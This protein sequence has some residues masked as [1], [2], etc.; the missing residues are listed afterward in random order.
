MG[1]AVL[2]KR[3]G[4]WTWGRAPAWAFSS[5]IAPQLHSDLFESAI[6]EAVKRADGREGAALACQKLRGRGREAWA[7]LSLTSPGPGAGAGAEPGPWG[8][9]VDALGATSRRV[10]LPVFPSPRLSVNCRCCCWSCKMPRGQVAVS[11]G[12]CDEPC[13]LPPCAVS[14]AA[15]SG[16]LR[17]SFLFCSGG[18]SPEGEEGVNLFG[19]GQ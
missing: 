10:T 7:A 11:R 8:L 17:T 5:I 12:A 6:W 9:A 3:P 14:E 13:P 2:P 4:A 1:V 19:T 16:G 18:V 15:A